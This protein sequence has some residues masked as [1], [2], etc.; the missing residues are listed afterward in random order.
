[1]SETTAAFDGPPQPTLPLEE[2]TASDLLQNAELGIFL[3]QDWTISYVNP[4]MAR[5]VG[6]PASVLLGA[7]HDVFTAAEHRPH[8]KKVM[9]RRLVGKEGRWGDM[10]CVR[11]DGSIFD[12]RVFA[13]RIDHGGSPAVLVTMLDVS[14]LKAALHRAEWNAQM[15]ARTE[16]LSRTGSMEVEFPRGTVRLSN[17]LRVLLGCDDTD[18]DPST[19]EELTWLPEEERA[20]VAGIWRAAVAGEPFE[21]QHRVVSADGARLTVLHRGTLLAND[22]KRQIGIA[23]LQ[24]IT[25]QREAEQRIQELASQDEVTGLPNR[26]HLL[27]QMDAAMHAA[28]WSEGRV[29]LMAIEIPQIASVKSSMGFGAGDTLAMGI[30]ARLREVCGDHIAVGQIG[31]AEFGLVFEGDAAGNDDAMR[32]QTKAILEGLSVPVR[33]GATDV[34]PLGLA[35]VAVFPRDADN[36]ATLLEAAQAARLDATPADSVAFFRPEVNQRAVRLM[37]IEGAL[38]QAIGSDEFELHYQPQVDL[39]SGAIVGAEALLRWTSHE[40]GQVSPAEF[41]PVAERSGLIGAISEW[42][43]RTACAAVAGWQR[44]GCPRVRVGVNLS[45]AEL[46]RPDLAAQIQRVLVGAG[47]DPACLSIELTEGTVMADIEHAA[48]ALRELKMLGVEIAL[49]DFGTGFSSLNYLCRLPIDVVKVDRSF[50]HDVTAPVEEVSVTRAIINMAHG[51]KMKVLAE[52]VETEGQLSLLASNGC[53]AI[54]GFW[55]SRPVPAADFEAMLASGKCLPEPFL[56]QGR[57]TRTLLLVDDEDNIVSSLRRLLRRDGYKIITASGGE[58][59][60]R[61]LAEHEVDVIVSDQRMPGMTG[62]EFLHRAKALYPNTVRMVLS[63]YTELQS[64]ID[65]VNEGAIYKF[66]TKP[67]DDERLRGHVAEAFRQ[68]ELADENRRLAQQV[69]TANAD[70]AELNSRLEQLLS[71]QRAH[72]DMLT[73]SAGSMRQLVEELPAALA[74]IDPDGQIVFV[75][76]EAAERLPG[77]G[78]WIGRNVRDTWPPALV[79]SALSNDTAP[80]E[81][82]FDGH[83]FCITKR[84]LPSS[85]TSQSVLLLFNPQH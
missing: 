24:D 37:R 52:G 74:A 7:P 79:T 69:E 80:T 12:V 66:L 29:A 43:L 42:V 35:G 33:L 77:A 10:K 8:V 71:Q 28:R 11:I 62:V 54:Q 34:F 26:A 56:T 13:R 19:I 65:A 41:I 2:V 64:I 9:E 20:Y 31:D 78:G 14:E 81:A 15:L 82:Q 46:Q 60:L 51:L 53:D 40:L 55:F 73:A 58:E 38:R 84:R 83:R 5:M 61:R 75:N 45:P 21:F 47:V 23:L 27:D 50:V 22:S 25:A 48:Q 85:S 16:S 72:A 39:S 18:D 6:V 57:K 1:M 68:K 76:R 63:G 59:G 36:A 70:L 32:V 30:A 49:D 3:V 17:G 44:Q 4:A 67:W